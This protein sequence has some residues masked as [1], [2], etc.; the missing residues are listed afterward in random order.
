MMGDGVEGKALWTGQTRDDGE[1][2]VARDFCTGKHRGACLGA[3]L[4]AGK[5]PDLG[6]KWIKNLRDGYIVH[7]AA[8]MRI[9][10]PSRP[11]LLGEKASERH[12]RPIMFRLYK[13]LQ[14]LLPVKL[15]C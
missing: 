11:V 4:K 8:G 10:W 2:T 3:V 5:M 15:S 7:N 12:N 9:L 6:R 14:I 13:Q 1:R